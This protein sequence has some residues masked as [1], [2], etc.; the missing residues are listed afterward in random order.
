MSP[1]KCRA[2]LAFS[3][4]TPPLHFPFD[5]GQCVTYL[6]VLFVHLL[7]FLLLFFFRVLREQWIRAKY[8]RLEFQDI[9]KQTYLTGKK[10]GM[11][12]KRGKG[13]SKFMAR[14]FIL[15]EEKNSLVYYTRHDVSIMQFYLV[16][17]SP[18]HSTP[19]LPYHTLSQIS[20]LN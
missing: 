16:T 13:D 3:I 20:H 4:K 7:L 9:A 2:F 6:S 1:W 15:D 18:L 12:F 8:E 10:S 11:L 5:T 19:L 14:F 17:P